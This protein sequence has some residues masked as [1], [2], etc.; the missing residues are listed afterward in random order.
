MSSS[1][2]SCISRI[3]GLG[4]VPVL[5]APQDRGQ[6]FVLPNQLFLVPDLFLG[7]GLGGFGLL[8]FLDFA[9]SSPPADLVRGRF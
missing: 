4:G 3:S 9:P 1:P 7:Q 6:I 5:W 8:T 2:G